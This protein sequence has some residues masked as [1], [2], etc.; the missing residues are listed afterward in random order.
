MFNKDFLELASVPVIVHP[1]ANPDLPAPLIVLCLK[2]FEHL[3]HQLDL[4]AAKNSL[5]LKQDIAEFQK[6]VAAWFNQNLN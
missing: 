6:V 3:G 5:E 1:P 4:E 2:T